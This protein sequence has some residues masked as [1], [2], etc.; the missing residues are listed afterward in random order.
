M[1]LSLWGWLEA[2]SG[3]SVWAAGFG[4]VAI[5][6]GIF[7]LS[8]LLLGAPEARQLPALLLRRSA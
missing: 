2:M 8:S 5:G 7:W 6:G 4:G 3:A 1:G